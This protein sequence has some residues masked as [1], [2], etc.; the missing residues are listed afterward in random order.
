MQGADGAIS[1]L[2]FVFVFVLVLSFSSLSLGISICIHECIASLA[3]LQNAD[4]HQVRCRDDS[5]CLCLVV[6]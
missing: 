2:D 1:S 5:H 6:L 3:S 4:L